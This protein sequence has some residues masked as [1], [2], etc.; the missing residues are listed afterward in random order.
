MVSH[1]CWTYVITVWYTPE[2]DRMLYVSYILIKIFLKIT[3]LKWAP[4]E[5]SFP[6]MWSVVPCCFSGDLPT[7][8][9]NL[10]DFHCLFVGTEMNPGIQHLR[11]TEAPLSMTACF[12]CLTR[13]RRLVCFCWN[14]RLPPRPL[15]LWSVVNWPCHSF[16]ANSRYFLRPACVGVNWTVC[17]LSCHLGVGQVSDLLRTVCCSAG[18]PVCAQWW[19]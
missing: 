4:W 1:H 8:H 11:R 15:A 2:T 12:Q 7:S 16:N 6:Q 13:V 10:V 9:F 14:A 3:K 5:K 18:S 17:S 19:K